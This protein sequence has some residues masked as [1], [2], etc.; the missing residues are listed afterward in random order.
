MLMDGSEKIYP[1]VQ[2]SGHGR[3]NLMQWIADSHWTEGG[4]NSNV[5]YPRMGVSQAEIANNIQ[6]STWWMRNGSFLRLKQ[7]ELGYTLPEAVTKKMKMQML[8][9]Y[10]SANNVASFSK[11]KLWDTEMGN[12][13]LGYPIQLVINGGIQI[14][15]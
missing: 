14:G 5:A 10:V 11:F 13:G 6:P 9:V 8:R 2:T 7:V 15:F 12:N 1:F 3:L 4:D